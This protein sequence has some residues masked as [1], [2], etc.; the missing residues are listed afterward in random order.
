MALTGALLLLLTHLLLGGVA[1]KPTCDP[2]TCTPCPER[3]LEGPTSTTAGGCCPPC[4]PPCACPPHLES[5]CEMQGF[6]SGRVPA[7]RSFYIDFARKL[8]TCHPGAGITCA[9]LCPPLPQT[10]Q[11]V[12]SPVADGCPRCVCYDQDEMAV[13]AGTTTVRGTQTCSCP[14]QGG[15]LQCSG[16]EGKE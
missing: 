14:P 8:C 16:G 13:P 5:E 12:G 11:A 9:P 3:D 15:Q 1:P 7:G 6:S 2:S 4:P 10:C